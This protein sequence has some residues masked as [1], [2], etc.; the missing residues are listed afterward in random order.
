MEKYL[1]GVLVEPR[2][3]IV[4]YIDP[5][6]P[7]KWI[8]YLIQGINDWQVAFERAGFKNA[9][10]GKISP[11]ESED[12]TFSLEDARHNAII[13]KPSDIANASGPSV[14]DPRSGEILEAHINWYHNIM[15]L[16]R[17][18]YICTGSSHRSSG[19]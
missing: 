13:Y 9:I 6:T 12:S 4:Y 1:R 17:N 5:T 15:T 14:I 11:A 10:I 19:P 18:W 3:P 16:L 2:K 8:P 7:R